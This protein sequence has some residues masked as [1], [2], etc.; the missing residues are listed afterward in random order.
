MLRHDTIAVDSW[1]LEDI[2]AS[3]E[4]ARIRGIPQI[5]KGDFAAGLMIRSAPFADW[6]QAERQRLFDLAVSALETVLALD[7][8]DG[9]PSAALKTAQAIIAIDATH[10]VA[11][12]C[13]LRSC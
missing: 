5:Y 4:A 13:A 1:E 9:E 10:E 2:A 8:A 11:H 12:R 6:L 3:G 7:E